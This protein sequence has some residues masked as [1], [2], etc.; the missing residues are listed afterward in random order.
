MGTLA[1]TRPQPVFRPSL[2]W[3]IVM[4]LMGAL[5][6][7]LPLVSSIGVARFIG[8]LMIFDG[9]AQ[10]INAFR[11]KGI[12]R[13][14][15]KLTVAVLYLVAGIYLS[16]NPFLAVVAL[17]FALAL[18]FFIQGLL[19]LTNYVFIGKERKS[20]WVLLNG[21]ISII[22]GAMIWRH[23]PSSSPWVLGQLV[24]IGLLVT[25]VTRLI[26]ALALRKRTGDLR[27]PHI[28]EVQPA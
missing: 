3:P 7:M 11:S 23:W 20:P 10:G 17:T 18:F 2:V 16:L 9:V 28:P 27:N 21:V 13:L 12:G 14:P 19:E 15:W 22:L 6:I 25:G 5:A 8:W 26:M 1:T 24:G 4:I